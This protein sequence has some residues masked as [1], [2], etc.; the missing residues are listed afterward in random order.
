MN[1]VRTENLTKSYGDVA[2]VD[3]VSLTLEPNRIYGLIGR[4]GAGKTTLM[5]LLMGLTL[6]TTGAIWLFG[7][8]APRPRPEQLRRVGALIESPGL[9]DTM[10]A[11]ENLRYHRLI[12]GIPSDSR[13]DELLDIVGL[14]NTGNKAAK[15]FSLGMRQRLGI[16]IALVSNPELILLDEPVNGLDPAGVVDMRR[17]FTRLHRERNVTL[18]I[19]SH[20]FP[21]LYQTATDYILMDRGQIKQTLTID[22]LESR[23][24]HYLRIGTDDPARLTRVLEE[25]FSTRN[26]TVMADGSVRLF[27]GL[28]DPASVLR[29]LVRHDIYP[30]A[31][32]KEGESLESYFLSVVGGTHQAPAPELVDTTGKAAS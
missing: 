17:L 25:E 1:I 27:D 11:R 31:F 18:V 7:A 22:E 21:E 16:A 19:S 30:Y 6:P 20:N 29:G 12:R 23:C 4:N 5:R 13:D 2:A 24:Q 3:K 8:P 15:D 32:A 10:S 14:S 26:F 9:V 28:E